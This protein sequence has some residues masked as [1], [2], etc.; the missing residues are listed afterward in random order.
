MNFFDFTSALR[1]TFAWTSVALAATAMGC[2]TMTTVDDP[3]TGPGVDAQVDAGPPM[4]MDS[5]GFPPPTEDTCT[6]EGMGA[7]LG[8]SCASDAACNDGCF[9][10]GA[11]V[12]EEGTCVEGEDPCLD[13]VECTADVCLEE[14]NRCFHDPQHEM[15]S[16]GNACNGTELCDL[17]TG[18]GPSSPLYCNDESS[19]TVD[20]CDPEMGCVFTPRDLDGDGYVD[21][22][23]G[24]DDCDDDPR[25][26]SDI[27]PGATEDCTNRRDDDCD[28][29]RDFLDDECLP[30]N[31]TC[32]DATVL[33]GPGTYSGSTRSLSGDYSLACRSGSG[34]DAVFRFTLTD[35]SNVT[36]TVAGGGS[37]AAVT[38]RDWASCA[39]GPELRCN[40]GSPPSAVANSLPAGDYAI[41]VQTSSGGA[42]FDLNLSIDSPT[43]PVPGDTCSGAIDIT[44]APG[45]VP[46]TDLRRD[47]LPSCSS[48]SS[49]YDDAY[50]YF[51]LSAVQDVTLTTNANGGW[52]YTG[53]DTSCPTASAT[54]LR[55]ESGSGDQTFTWRS[56]PAGTYHVAVSTSASSGDV[57][58]EVDIR[59]PTPIPPN[60]RCSGAIMLTDGYSDTGTTVDFADDASGCTG[61]GR[62]D[63]FYTFTLSTRRR[64]LINIADADGGSTSFYLT[65]RDSCSSSTNLACASGSAPSINEVL[66][67]GTYYLMVET[68][69]SDPSDFSI[70]SFFVAP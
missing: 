63:A 4:R 3:D 24:G 15:C 68:F 21:G 8:E 56:L 70:N 11:E 23:C 48:S 58:A 22:R 50:F 39:S 37:G 18:C 9:C 12:C 54:E 53:I 2:T 32:A 28:G 7:T 52:H 47:T 5:G 14:A 38:I 36:A 51:T 10:N 20:S 19:C 61:S 64:A 44:S 40:S 67:P 25:F 49:S 62:L 42:A 31:G 17:A 55:C 41:I 66:D 69:S 13:D 6:E 45:T 46:V 16:D 26:G 30:T 59:P 65:L 1:A 43:P 34:A 27:Y 60:D 35:V 29:S 57:T 33:P